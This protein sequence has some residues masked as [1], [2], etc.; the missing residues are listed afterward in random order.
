MDHRII[1]PDGHAAETDAAEPNWARVTVSTS[2][3]LGERLRLVKFVAYGWSSRRSV[4]ALRD[5]VA[6]ALPARW[7]PDG[8]ALPPSRRTRSPNS[9]PAPTSRSTDRPRSSRPSGSACSTTSRP[10]SAPSSARSRPRADRAPATTGTRSGTPS[11]SSCRCSARPRR[12]PP[13]TR[14]V[15]GC[16][17]WT[18]PRTGPDLRSGRRGVP[19]AHDPRPGVLGV[20]A[21]RHGRDPRQRR[22]RGRGRPLLLVD[23]RRGVRR[24]LRAP[25]LV[26]TAR[27]WMSLG[28]HGDDGRFHIDGVTGPDEYTALS[29]D[30]IYTNLMAAQNLRAAAQACAHRD[31][32]R[33]WRSPPTRSL[34]GWAAARQ[35]CR[36]LRRASRVH[37]QCRGFTDARGVGLRA[38]GPRRRVPA[39]AATRRTSSCTAGR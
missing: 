11:R 39:A 37:E 20:L 10:A 33:H 26:E 35:R 21:R 15:G 25:L 17:R 29:D 36:P 31:G 16:R 28:Y 18:W 24:E 7:T 2:L 34:P 5:Q 23:R 13:R 38:L 8:T 1:A 14:C 19:V 6:A 12:T 4:P 22:H 9:G 3:D 27:L 32:R 30:N